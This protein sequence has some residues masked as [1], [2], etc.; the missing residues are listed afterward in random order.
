MVTG[1][2]AASRLAPVAAAEI[3]VIYTTDPERLARAGRL[4][5]TTRG[6]NVLLA[7]PYDPLVFEDTIDSGVVTYVSTAPARAR[8]PHRQRPH[9]RRGRGNHWLDAQERSALAQPDT[10]APP[11]KTERVMADD[12]PRI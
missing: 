8:L 1:S 12:G 4:R 5:P 11:Q 9:G 6:A 2:I 3:G 10:G 7:V